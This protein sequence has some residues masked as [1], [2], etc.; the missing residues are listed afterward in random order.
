EY[1]SRPERF[2]FAEDSIFGSNFQEKKRLPRY[3]VAQCG[4]GLAG[5]SSG[6]KL[7]DFWL[8]FV[9]FICLIV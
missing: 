4:A 2:A 8:F 1:S 7:F 6:L 5:R 9:Y 3:N